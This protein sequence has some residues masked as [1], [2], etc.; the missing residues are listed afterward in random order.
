MREYMK[1]QEVVDV[2]SK[3][4]CNCCGKEIVT[5]DAKFDCLHL[6]KTW[7]YFSNKDG[8]QDNLDI[9]EDCYDQWVATFKHPPK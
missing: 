7:G 8:R 6:E 1:K 9:C 2:V 4:V 5:N 3:V